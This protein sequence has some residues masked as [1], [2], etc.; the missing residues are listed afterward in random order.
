MQSNDAPSLRPQGRLQR[1]YSI[2]RRI[3]RNSMTD[4]EKRM[5]RKEKKN[6]R[7]NDI[8][9]ES[10]DGTNFCTKSTSHLLFSFLRKSRMRSLDSLE[11]LDS[12]HG[13]MMRGKTMMIGQLDGAEATCL[14]VPPARGFHDC[15]SWQSQVEMQAAS[16][17]S[18]TRIGKVTG[19]YI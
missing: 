6:A 14:V 10:V 18:T 13:E 1:L 8:M 17:E 2:I 12:L 19:R 9:Y 4:R 15:A 16:T 5:T 11:S 7:T 3:E